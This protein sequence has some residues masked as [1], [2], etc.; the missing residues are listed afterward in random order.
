MTMPDA[1]DDQ[2]H[3]FLADPTNRTVDLTT[4]LAR[5]TKALGLHHSVA[6]LADIQQRHLVPLTDV[7]ATLPIDDSLAGWT[8]RTQ[9]LRGEPTESGAMT[10]WFPLL[11]GAERLGVLAVY[12]HSPP[13]P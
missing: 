1:G 13:P 10:A 8:Y 4:A 12:G 3:Q 11:D 2:L 5:C 6:Y 9:S 7:T